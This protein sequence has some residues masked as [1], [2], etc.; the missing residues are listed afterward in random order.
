MHLFVE[1]PS[2]RAGLPQ[3]GP[4]PR[5]QLPANLCCSRTSL[6]PLTQSREIIFIQSR[7]AQSWLETAAR[8]AM[9]EGGNG[10]FLFLQCHQTSSFHLGAM[11][12]VLRSSHKDKK[13]IWVG[14]SLYR[15]EYLPEPGSDW[16]HHCHPYPHPSNQARARLLLCVIPLEMKKMMDKRKAESERSAHVLC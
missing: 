16:Q 10:V 14:K 5:H 9:K 11:R 13:V 7:L 1:I 15:M 8:T 2:V 4:V 3:H 6:F 12:S